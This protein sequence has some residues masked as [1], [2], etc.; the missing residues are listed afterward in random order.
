M[1]AVR[2]KTP[3]YQVSSAGARWISRFRHQLVVSPFEAASRLKRIAGDCRGWYFGGR[4]P[5][6]AKLFGLTKSEALTISYLSRALPPPP[7]DE[8][9]M[10]LFT[11]RL[12]SAPPPVDPTW[13]PFVKGYLRKWA[14]EG[15]QP[16]LYTAPS[17]HSLWVIPGRGA[18]TWRA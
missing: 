2:K 15:K 13:K 16:Q 14:P 12:L 5:A 3:E 8:T 17:A 7:L 10:G 11:E 9:L 1:Q 4:Q 6:F 18:G